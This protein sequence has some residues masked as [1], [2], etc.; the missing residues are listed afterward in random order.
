MKEIVAKLKVKK[1]NRIIG[2]IVTGTTPDNLRQ[3]P[4]K[5]WGKFTLSQRIRFNALHAMFWDSVNYHP[6]MTK[7][8]KFNEYRDT[9]AYNFALLV[10]WDEGDQISKICRHS[11]VKAQG[12]GGGHVFKYCNKCGA[13]EPAE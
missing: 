13:T 8:A 6:D 11:F 12:V 10:T 2:P 3:V 7:D 5:I 4:A 9:L 1:K